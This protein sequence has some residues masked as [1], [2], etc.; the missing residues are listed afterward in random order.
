MGESAKLGISKIEASDKIGS[1]GK[2]AS[3]RGS[4]GVALKLSVES[5]KLK[6]FAEIATLIRDSTSCA[7]LATANIYSP[8]AK[9]SWS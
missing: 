9:A 4:V 6:F 7:I 8:E 5:A 2:S 1:L 3:N